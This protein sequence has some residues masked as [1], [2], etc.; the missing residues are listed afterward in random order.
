MTWTEKETEET[1]GVADNERLYRFMIIPE[2]NYWPFPSHDR[3][4]DTEKI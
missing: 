3:Y 2:V 1:K 4:C